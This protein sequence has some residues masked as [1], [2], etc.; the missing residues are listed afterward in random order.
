MPSKETPIIKES[1]KER[2]VDDMK[3]AFRY[4]SLPNLEDDSLIKM[5]FKHLMSDKEI[6]D[7]KLTI[8]RLHLCNFDN[9][10]SKLKTYES[11]EAGIII[12]HHISSVHS[13]Y[14]LSKLPSLLYS[15]KSFS[16]KLKNTSI[17]VTCQTS[18]LDGDKLKLARNSCD[19]VLEL[20]CF[21][22]LSGSAY[23]DYDGTIYVHK[24]MNCLS[25]LKC[26]AYHTSD[27]GFQFKLNRHFIVKKLS[28]P[29]DIGETTSRTA[30][31]SKPVE[32]TF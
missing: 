20:I 30:T 8:D 11:K 27:I 26:G 18:A 22:K 6:Q 1:I 10:L 28:L 29:P 14:P 15:L 21:D 17:V 5:N 31:S 13:P 25:A 9:L 4:Q 16:R 19:N 3:I 12:V 7:N 2:I 23:A 32:Q 24:L